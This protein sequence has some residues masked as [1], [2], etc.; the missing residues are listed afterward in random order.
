MGSNLQKRAVKW[1]TQPVS[2]RSFWFW[3]MWSL[4]AFFS[5]AG[6]LR[7]IDSIRDHDWLTLAGVYPSP[8]YISITGGLWGLVG[9]VALIWIGAGRTGYRFVGSVAALFFAVTFWVDR[10]LFS[11][12]EG[13]LSNVGFA[14]LATLLLLAAVWRTYHPAGEI[15]ELVRGGKSV[16]RGAVNQ[17]KQGQVEHG[18]VRSGD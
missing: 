18:E 12:S 8:V 9:F 11:R 7:M 15:K 1:L 4:F 10:L 5:L 13:A 2:R 17:P 16:E 6:W 3:G 14:L